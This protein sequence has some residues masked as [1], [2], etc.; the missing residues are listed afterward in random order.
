MELGDEVTARVMM[1]EAAEC[2]RCPSAWAAR[3][4]PIGWPHGKSLSKLWP[5]EAGAVK[6]RQ[7]C[8]VRLCPPP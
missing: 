1:D 3:P 4:L 8:V 7:V 5:Q 6:G 2:A